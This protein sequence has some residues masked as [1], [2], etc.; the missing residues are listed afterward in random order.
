MLVAVSD[1]HAESPPALT[2]HLREAIET[3][4]VVCHAGD[5]TSL[6]SLE[7]F[8]SLAD[9]F[10]AVHGNADAVPVQERLPATATVE[11][12]GRRILVVHGHEHDRTNLSFLARQE[13]ADIVV[14][15]HTHRPGIEKRG[16]RVI[17]NP[18]S[19][20]D[21]RGSRPAYVSVGQADG[22]VFGRLQTPDGEPVERAV[23]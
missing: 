5:F 14:V 12:L 6:A 11:H 1:T 4:D 20:A 18:G 21:P 7:T 10:V 13:G 16:S 9:T 17:V 23:L 19:H 2:P 8:E 3:A 15:G 22:T